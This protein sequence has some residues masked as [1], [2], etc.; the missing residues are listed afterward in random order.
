MATYTSKLN[1][2]KPAGTE[3]INISDINGNMDTLD[4]AVGAV[5]KFSNEGEI[6]TIAQ[7]DALLNTKLDSM[8]DMSTLCFTVSLSAAVDNYTTGRHFVILKKGQGST[9]AKA[10]ISHSG[11]GYLY[12]A[13]KATNGWT[14]Q[15]YK[16]LSGDTAVQNTA[17]GTI[18]SLAA[19]ASTNVDIDI[20]IPSGY[21][22]LMPVGRY[23][24][25]GLAIVSCYQTTGAPTGY[26]RIRC[27]VMNIKSSSVTN[28]SVTASVIFVPA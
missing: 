5:Y 25:S 4:A 12:T 7:F 26:V 13:H 8:S 23:T 15:M 2:K 9:Y 21:K 22:I 10:I 16:P 27:Y 24:S 18:A 1:L 14:H 17:S 3:N 6:S 11:T 28:E 19:G 20:A